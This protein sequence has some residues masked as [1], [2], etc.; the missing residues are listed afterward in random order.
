MDA[1]RSENDGIV[2][3]G[4]LMSSGKHVP[5][6]RLASILRY[7]MYHNTAL[8]ENDYLSYKEM[9]I[10]LG[11]DLE[12]HLDEALD[13]ALKQNIVNGLSPGRAEKLKKMLKVEYRSIF[14]LCLGRSDPAKVP[15]MDI[16]V[17][18]GSLPV[19]VRVRR[20][21]PE[22][23]EFLSRYVRELV[24]M[25]FLNPSPH[26]KW[27]CAP[28]LVHKP[29]SKAKYRMTIDLR[30]INAATEKHS[31]PMPHIESELSDLSGATCFAKLDF[32]SGYWQLP[33]HPNSQV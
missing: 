10:D 5:E 18:P 8:C 25:R 29:D 12:D 7:G 28:L 27:Q 4:N 33:V 15:P 17:K 11:D 20:Y 3:A 22:Q 31:W 24:D 19:R 23:R 30:P 13:K 9:H 21:P 2:D 32:V 6:K 26:A 1:A 16:R 14:R